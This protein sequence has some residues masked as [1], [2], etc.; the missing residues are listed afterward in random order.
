VSSSRKRATAHGRENSNRCVT[1]WIATHV[2]KSVRSSD[3]SFSNAAMFGTTNSRAPAPPGGGRRGR[4]AE[5]VLREV[6]EDRAHLR[7]EQQGRHLPQHLR[8]RVGCALRQ[9]TTLGGRDRLAE[10]GRGGFE[11]R[12][13]PSR[14]SAIH[15]A[16]GRPSRPDVVRG[17]EPVNT[18]T[19]MS[20]TRTASSKVR[21]SSSSGAGSSLAP[22]G[23]GDAHLARQLQFTGRSTTGHTLDLPEQGN[24]VPDVAEGRGERV[25]LGLASSSTPRSRSGLLGWSACATACSSASRPTL[26]TSARRSRSSRTQGGRHV[27]LPRHRAGHSPAGEVT[28]L[29]YEAWRTSRWRVSRRPPEELLDGCRCTRWPSCTGRA[30]S[31]WGTSRGRR[32]LLGASCGGRSSVPARDPIVS[33][34]TSRSG[35]GAPG[36]RGGP[37]VM[38]PDVDGTSRSTRHREHARLQAGRGDRVQRAEP[39]WP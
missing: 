12:S 15:S 35:E 36:G 1:S 39:S 27:R 29:T 17:L 6:P 7:A 18:V 24:V 38:G 37:L 21:R 28:G 2:R 22:R 33:S 9:R 5:H 25:P 34:R 31:R 3:Q 32:M 11:Q 20:A 23:R 16:G 19:C 26:S 14:L 10:P 8:H 30:T 4:T 13:Q